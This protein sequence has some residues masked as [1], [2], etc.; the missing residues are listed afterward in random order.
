MFQL[1]SNGLTLLDTRLVRQREDQPRFDMCPCVSVYTP[2]VGFCSPSPGRR[3][4]L[5]G[6]PGWCLRGQ[7]WRFRGGVLVQYVSDVGHGPGCGLGGQYGQADDVDDVGLR[8]GCGVDHVVHFRR[9]VFSRTG[10]WSGAGSVAPQS[11]R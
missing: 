4:V 9:G 8:F 6:W 2:A 10:G 7:W 5:A 11:G 3:T 1:A